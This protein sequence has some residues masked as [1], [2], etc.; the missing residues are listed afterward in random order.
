VVNDL[1][2]L[3]RENVAAPPPDGLDVD[4]LM[5]AG[6]RRFRR[7]RAAVLG[8]AAVVVAG[9][10][11]G[12]AVSWPSGAGRTGVAD[13]PPA[14]DAPTVRLAD[15]KAAVEGRDY[16]VLASYTNEDLDRDNGQYFD[17][18]T[19]DGLILFRDGPR[20][21]QHYARMAL[22]D[23]AT[24]AKDWLP[25]PPGIEGQTWPIELGTDRLVLLAPDDRRLS[26]PVAHVFDRA[27][28]QWSSVE[29]PS[30]PGSD[31]RPRAVLGPDDRLYV[32]V[33]TTQG[34]PPEGGWPV[35]SDGEADD[36]DAEG[37]TYRLW[38][39]SLTDS[40][41]VRD[42]GMSVGEIA[43]TDSSMVWTDSTNGDAG[44]VHVRDLAT[45]EEHA[46]DPHTGERCNLLSFG[47]TDE[48]VMLSQ[49]CGTY[50]GGVRDDRVQILTTDGDQVVTLQ[51]SGIEGAVAGTGGA[52][53]VVTVTSYEGDR[54]GT[55]VYDLETGEFLRVS[56]EVSSYWLNALTGDGQFLWHTPVNDRRGATQSLGELLP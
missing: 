54:A 24:G 25:D 2:A 56:K 34:K 36:A 9:V 52:G 33:L 42:E 29:W 46:F 8:G 30:L 13:G 21:D 51:D 27:T 32:S 1:K 17:G 23:P 7:R 38:S 12:T 55:Y 39:V 31:S 43:F 37:D 19:D 14:P 49:Y 41:D 47:A 53:S 26:R 11:A 16:S 44:L 15:A 10:V 40:S 45:G 3:M 50:D 4:A 6:R 48:R 28:R 35:G 22:M 20:A 5:N 18:V